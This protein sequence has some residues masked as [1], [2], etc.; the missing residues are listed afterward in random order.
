M[1]GEHERGEQYSEQEMPSETVMPSSTTIAFYDEL[2]RNNN[3][4]FTGESTITSGDGD[5]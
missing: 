5:T 4:K 2:D 3:N 1:K